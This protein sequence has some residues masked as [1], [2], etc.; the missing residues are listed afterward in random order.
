MKFDTDSTVVC[1]HT[2]LCQ[3]HTSVN[4]YLVIFQYMI[5][6]ITLVCGFTVVQMSVTV[7]YLFV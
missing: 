1:Q 3:F 7:C 5:V 4:L 2:R 6:V